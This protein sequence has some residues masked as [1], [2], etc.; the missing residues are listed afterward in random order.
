MKEEVNRLVAVN[1]IKETQFVTWLANVV[2]VPK[3]NQK[4][5]MCVDFTNLNK[6]CPKDCY[7]LPRIDT[8]INATS[9]FKVLS[10]LDNFAGYH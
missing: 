4:W 5:R 9:G 6:P 2:M 8:L 1:F 3:P 10:F 7:P